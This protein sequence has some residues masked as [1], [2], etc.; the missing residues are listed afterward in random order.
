MYIYIYI[1][2]CVRLSCAHAQWPFLP[3]LFKPK[4]H[5]AAYGKGIYLSPISSISFGYS[6]RNGSSPFRPLCS[7]MFTE[8]PLCLLHGLIDILEHSIF[9]CGCLPCYPV[10]LYCVSIFGCW[11]SG[12]WASVPPAMPCFMLWLYKN[13][14]VIGFVC[15]HI[16]GFHLPLSVE[17]CK[18]V[19]RLIG[20]A[21][22]NKDFSTVCS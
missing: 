20:F 1:Y 21:G 18:D 15:F 14:F 16:F 4:L 22:D 6:G 7:P 8:Y 10:V 9:T 17:G 13:R 19:S 2:V 11:V 12:L 5:G 3:A